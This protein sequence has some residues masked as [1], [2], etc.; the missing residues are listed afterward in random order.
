MRLAR[1][2]FMVVLVGVFAVAARADATAPIDPV[3]HFESPDPACA[4]PY[5]VDLTYIGPDSPFFAVALTFE[6]VPPPPT[7]VAETPGEFSCD[8]L[9]S[10]VPA[11]CTVDQNNP[12]DT[13]FYGFTITVPAPVLD[14]ETFSL[15]VAG[16][17]LTLTLPDTLCTGDTIACPNG[18]GGNVT[19]DPVP[20]P[21]TALL[22][23]SGLGLLFLAGVGKR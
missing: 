7:G 5:C 19:V 12:T 23:M 2:M 8:F 14:G 22:F 4:P 1:V 15:T 6:S 16:A 18:V 20:E 10:G 17:P 3:A 9:V 11:P 13:L 21:S